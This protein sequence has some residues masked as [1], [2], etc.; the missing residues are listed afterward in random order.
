[1]A[2]PEHLRAAHGF[3]RWDEAMYR[4]HYG[5]LPYADLHTADHTD[6]APPDH[7]HILAEGS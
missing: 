7:E 3:G 6:H 2:I 4:E 1:M 5:D